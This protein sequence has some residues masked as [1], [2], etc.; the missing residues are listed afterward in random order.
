[1]HGKASQELHPIEGNGLFDGPVAVIFGQEGYPSIG[2]VQDALVGNGH[3]VGVLAQVPDHVAGTC[4]RGFAVD[5]PFGLESLLYLAVNKGKL[6]L[7]P[8]GAF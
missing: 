3:P 5:H 2:N 1:M 4:Q 8:Q 7:L 6:V